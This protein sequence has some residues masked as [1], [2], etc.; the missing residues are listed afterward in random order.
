[1]STK[2]TTATSHVRNLYLMKTLIVKF[3]GEYVV[4]NAQL[5]YHFCHY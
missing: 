4:V 3:S 1:M 2:N 5:Q